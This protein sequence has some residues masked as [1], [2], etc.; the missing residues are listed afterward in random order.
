M[1]EL[2]EEATNRQK[3]RDEQNRLKSFHRKESIKY[4]Q[5]AAKKNKDKVGNQ[6]REHKKRVQ[7]RWYQVIPP[8]D[9]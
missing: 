6:L 7:E 3:E 8:N 4:Q 5:A 1:N 2:Y 9:I